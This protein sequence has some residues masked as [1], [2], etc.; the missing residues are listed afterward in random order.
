MQ[1]KCN[2]CPKQ[3]GIHPGQSGECRIRVN[4]DGRLKSVVYGYPSAIHMDPIEKK[5]LFHF[6]P[7]TKI[8]SIATVGCNLH[9]KNCQNWEISQTNPE[10]SEAY[11]MPPKNVVENAAKSNSRSI[12]YTYSDPVVFYEYTLDTS[13]IAR[14]NHM[15]NV[16]VTAGYINQDPLKRLLKYTDAANVDLKSMSDSFYREITS[17]TLA[18]V[19]DTLVL[20]R[21]MNVHLEVTNLLIPTLND[22]DEEIK[23]LAKWIYQNLGEEIPLHISKFFPQYKMRNLPPTPRETLIRAR[24]IAKAEGLAHVYIGNMQTENGETTFCPKCD[25]PL[26]IRNGYLIIEN[27]IG[28]GSCNKCQHKVYGK[29]IDEH[30]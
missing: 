22:K 27:N 7:G 3:C 21:K 29:W 26:I 5:P 9:C 2:L 24:E 23:K 6:L 19:L 12:A 13:V 18:P 30:L 28:N 20:I 14:E 1:I 10:E 15:Y 4:V 8:F 17:A 16:L 25:E 11:Y